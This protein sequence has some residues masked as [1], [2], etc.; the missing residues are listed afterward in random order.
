LPGDD[1]GVVEGRQH[2]EPSSPQPVDLILRIVLAVADNADFRAEP[3]D[4]VELF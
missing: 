1:V 3:A 2:D 4:F